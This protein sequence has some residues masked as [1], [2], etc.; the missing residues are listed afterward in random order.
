M[1]FFFFFSPKI[2]LTFHFSKGDTL[3]EMSKV[4]FLGIYLSELAQSVVK[5]TVNVLK[6]L[7][8]LMI[9]VLAVRNFRNCDLLKHLLFQ[10][11]RQHHWLPKLVWLSD[12]SGH[13]NKVKNICDER[14]FLICFMWLKTSFEIVGTIKNNHHSL[15]FAFNSIQFKIF[16]TTK[17][18]NYPHNNICMHA[19][20]KNNAFI[21]LGN[22]KCDCYMEVAVLLVEESTEN[23]SRKFGQLVVSYL[24]SCSCYQA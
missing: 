7:T 10:I 9:I 5:V 8:K 18:T 17:Q 3:H 23:R 14:G 16:L 6:F 22:Q 12:I 19:V 20:K 24:N 15:I 21:K 1:T 2:T 13:P 4:C 11:L